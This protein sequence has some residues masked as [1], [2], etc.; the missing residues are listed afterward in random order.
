MRP[1]ELEIV[2]DRQPPSAAGKYRLSLGQPYRAEKIDD[3][4]GLYALEDDDGVRF[5]VSTF[6]EGRFHA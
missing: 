4:L 5:N 2:F 1:D 3:E 6:G